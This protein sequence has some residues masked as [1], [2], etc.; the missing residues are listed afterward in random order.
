VPDIKKLAERLQWQA[1]ADAA[2]QVFKE[3]EEDLLTKN[4]AHPYVNNL[5]KFM[6]LQKGKLFGVPT[7]ANPLI[8]TLVG[9]MAGAGLGYGAGTLAGYV[10]PKDWDKKK[11]RRAMTLGGGLAGALP[12]LGIAGLNYAAGEN[13]TSDLFLRPNHPTQW[14]GPGP[15]PPPGYD[16]E[17]FF[18]KRSTLQGTGALGF[19]PIDVNEFNQVIWKDPRVA[20]PLP[21]NIQ[22]AASGLISG[23]AN[24]SGRQNSSYVMPQDVARMAMGMGAG[25]LS[26]A[27]VGRGLGALM[28]APESVQERLKT[29]GMWA[30]LI[31][32]LVPKAF[33][34]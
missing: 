31:Q 14:Q 20:R 18:G 4:A 11:L 10:A 12:G 33:G 13:L 29:T 15:V 19:T 2:V 21:N 17:H 8:S 6:Q 30:G 25:Y 16:A 23:A 22:A 9:G 26:G 7:T 34:G 3:H 32:A 27:V 5:M 24:L 28:G 1:V